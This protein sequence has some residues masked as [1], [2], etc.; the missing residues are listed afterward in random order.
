M[1]VKVWGALYP[2]ADGNVD[3]LL[4]ASG[5]ME[6]GPV[7]F[8]TEPP[9]PVAIGKFTLVNLYD[10]PDRI[11]PR[12]GQIVQGQLCDLIGRNLDASW[13]QLACAGDVRGWI[14]ARLVTVDG[15]IYG[16]RVASAQP[17]DP[18]GTPAP[19]PPT[20]T[21]PP[22]TPTPTPGQSN[23]WQ[24]AYF[25][26]GQLAGAPV[27]STAL[28]NL[29]LDWGVESPSISVADNNF[30]AR[31]ERRLDFSPAG[32]YRFTVRADDGVRVWLDNEPLVDEWHGSSNQ[33]YIVGRT[34]SGLHDLRIEYYEASG[35]AHI[36]F[37][38]EYVGLSPEW[39]AEY[40]TG[41]DLRGSP[42]LIQGEPRGVLP[43][44][45]NWGYGG[46]A[47]GSS[48]GTDFWSA[49][50]VGRF[51]FAGGDYYFRVVADD[52]V[53]L[54]LNDLLVID[55]WRDGYK[56][57]SN[58]VIGIGAGEHTIRV[59]YYERTGLASLRFWWYL[60]SASQDVQ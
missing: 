25:N 24:A 11:Y 53:R 20:P 10:G 8:R 28:A 39:N 31:F 2:D 19:L 3:G 50:W 54:Y 27:W 56:E 21:A 22:L 46:P 12:V 14:D 51:R 48:V 49:R 52:G 40:F 58:R 23:V 26:N 7:G 32:Y 30:S 57:L 47:V 45:Y 4:V 59:E 17:V 55:S 33:S 60:D 29:D 6:S 16:V 5:L 35:L 37:D 42:V 44:D 43:L 34:L 1:A 36:R 41:T 15:D 18:T 38:F 9:P 13:W